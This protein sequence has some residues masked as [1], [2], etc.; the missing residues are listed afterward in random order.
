MRL[1]DVLLALLVMT[2]IGKV[3]DL[4]CSDALDLLESKRLADRGFPVEL[5]TALRSRTPDIGVG[6]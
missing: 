4:G 5:R 2:E 6:C 3:R 1:Y